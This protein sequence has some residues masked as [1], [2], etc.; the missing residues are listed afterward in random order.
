VRDRALGFRAREHG[1][2][3]LR[4]QRVDAAGPRLLRRA[5]ME[6]AV[7][8]AAAAAEGAG[9]AAEAGQAAVAP[10]PEPEASAHAPAVAAREG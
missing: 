4:H 10:A 3:P 2:L 1:P 9:S 8:A 5:S 6:A 7:A